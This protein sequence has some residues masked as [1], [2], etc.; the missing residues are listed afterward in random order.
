HAI[1]VVAFIVTVATLML[2]GLT[3]PLLIR[4]L[5][6][7]S[8][9]DHDE[10]DRAMAAVRKRSR[11]AGKAFLAT[12]REEWA[13]KY[14]PAEMQAFDAFAKRMTKV[15]TDTDQAQEVEESL[16]RPSY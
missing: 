6:V 8:D 11:E 9:V 2:Q 5:G 3:L 15:E 10:D 13:S 1:V 16:P 14:S 12:Q 4:S 7:A